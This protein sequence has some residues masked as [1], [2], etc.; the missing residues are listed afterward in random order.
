MGFAFPILLSCSAILTMHPSVYVLFRSAFAVLLLPS[1]VRVPFDHLRL[2]IAMSF[3]RTGSLM[4][5]LVPSS[6]LY[7]PS[8]LHSLL[9]P[10]STVRT[11]Q[12]VLR[13]LI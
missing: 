12:E 2:V 3:C 6:V 13:S 4:A 7:V 5:L 9:L 10:T 8:V 1:V 11:I